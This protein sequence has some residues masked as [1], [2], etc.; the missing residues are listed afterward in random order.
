MLGSDEKVGVWMIVMVEKEEV[1]GALNRSHGDNRLASHSTASAG[2]Q[3]F[4]SD[5]LYA[6]YLKREGQRPGTNG[7]QAT[8]DT[9]RERRQVD[10]QFRDF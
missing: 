5:K 10:D 1:T 8:S 7:T 3:R 2:S 4:T 9:A 6:D